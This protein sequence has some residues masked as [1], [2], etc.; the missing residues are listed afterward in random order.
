MYKV[1]LGF[2]TR[3]HNI[4]VLKEIKDSYNFVSQIYYCTSFKLLKCITHL[5]MPIKTIYFLSRFKQSKHENN[6]VKLS[7]SILFKKGNLALKGLLCFLAEEVGN[8]V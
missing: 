5:K 4:Q 7:P 2:F 8:S 3:V 6:Q 1:T